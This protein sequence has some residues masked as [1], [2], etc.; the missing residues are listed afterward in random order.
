M[1][2]DL[3]T[4]SSKCLF[5][6]FK[7][8]ERLRMVD[9]DSWSLSVPP[10]LGKKKRKEAFVVTNFGFTH[11]HKIGA[12][13]FSFLSNHYCGKCY[14]GSGLMIGLNEITT[15]GQVV[16]NVL[17]T[18]RLVY[19]NGQAND[20]VCKTLC[21]HAPQ[22]IPICNDARLWHEVNRRLK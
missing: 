7:R 6:L 13:G 11:F 20:F 14:N 5:G 9:S 16:L 17:S 8:S 4:E 2:R 18:S 10:L 12:T 3:V 19:S 21:F 15:S 22:C 1:R